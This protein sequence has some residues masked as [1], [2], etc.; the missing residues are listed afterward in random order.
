MGVLHYEV[1][2]ARN[3]TCKIVASVHVAKLFLSIVISVTVI[4]PFEFSASFYYFQKSTKETGK[5][6]P[7]EGTQAKFQKKRG[8]NVTQSGKS[9]EKATKIME[10]FCCILSQ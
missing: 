5:N 1:G 2:I 4:F 3:N 9:V 7:I 10:I 8:S 6:K